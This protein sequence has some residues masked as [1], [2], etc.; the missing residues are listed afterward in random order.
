[1]LITD[2]DGRWD[3]FENY[4]ARLVSQ[5]PSVSLSREEWQ[6]FVYMK[7]YFSEDY[8]TARFKPWI[9]SV[10]NRIRRAKAAAKAPQS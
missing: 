5:D 9:P 1:M 6:N 7:Y 10:F 2:K 8:L 3:L 4:S